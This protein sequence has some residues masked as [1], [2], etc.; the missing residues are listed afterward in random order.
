MCCNFCLLLNKHLSLTCE[1]MHCHWLHRSS[2]DTLTNTRD[3]RKFTSMWGLVFRWSLP[4]KQALDGSCT[5]SRSPRQKAHSGTFP[6]TPGLGRATQTAS[7]VSCSSVIELTVC[8]QMQFPGRSQ[9]H[10]SWPAT[11]HSCS[12]QM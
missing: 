8:V 4:Q 5:R 6:A 11:I 3:L 2:S 7:T 12:C 9:E 10:P 1:A